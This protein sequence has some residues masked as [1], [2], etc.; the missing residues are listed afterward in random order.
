M[1]ITLKPIT[2]RIAMVAEEFAMYY[3]G[4]ELID[5]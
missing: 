3:E 1:S 5:N 4:R 2:E